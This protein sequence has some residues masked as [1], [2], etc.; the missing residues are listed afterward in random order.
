MAAKAL[1]MRKNDVEKA[2]L[3]LKAQGVEK[4]VK[5]KKKLTRKEMAIA[6]KQQE[7]EEERERK[8]TEDDY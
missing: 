4:L 5:I 1:L 6:K 3:W 2:V 7:E 8:E